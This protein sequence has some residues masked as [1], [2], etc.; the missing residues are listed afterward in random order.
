MTDNCQ[1]RQRDDWEGSAFWDTD[2]GETFVFTED[3]PIENGLRFCCFCGKP[4]E[5][6][7]AEPD[8]CDD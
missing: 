3:T 2:C 6:V 1:W 8:R 4:L 7:L 5:Q